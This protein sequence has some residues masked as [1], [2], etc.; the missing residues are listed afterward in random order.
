[1][2]FADGFVNLRL[3]TLTG[4]YSKMTTMGWVCTVTAMFALH[5]DCLSDPSLDFG[6][7]K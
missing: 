5:I 1:M 6:G 2:T 7:I 4:I 3:F